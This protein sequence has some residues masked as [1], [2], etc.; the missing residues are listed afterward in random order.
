MRNAR[1]SEAKPCCGLRQALD[2]VLG[3]YKVKD[4]VFTDLTIDWRYNE[5]HGVLENIST[6]TKYSTSSNHTTSWTGIETNIG[7]RRAYYENPRY[8]GPC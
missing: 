5:A 4:Q 3:M 1:R 6:G 7:E 2:L 8:C